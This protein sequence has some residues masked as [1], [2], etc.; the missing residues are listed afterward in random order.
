MTCYDLD[1]LRRQDHIKSQ[2]QFQ[3]QAAKPNDMNAQQRITDP[4]MDIEQELRV[5]FNVKSKLNPEE[6]ELTSEQTM[7]RQT[8][9]KSRYGLW[10]GGTVILMALIVTLSVTGTI[11]VSQC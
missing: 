11:L 10:I 6:M 2:F 9:G 3:H 7:A 1:P 5:Q 4:L 8:E